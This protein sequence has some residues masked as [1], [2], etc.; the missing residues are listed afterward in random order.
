MG[1]E[2]EE[3]EQG[4]T[5]SCLFKPVWSFALP[6]YCLRM[7]MYSHT[8]DAL[9]MHIAHHSHIAACGSA[10]RPIRRRLHASTSFIGLSLENRAVDNDKSLLPDPCLLDGS[11]TKLRISSSLSLSLSLL[12]Q[13]GFI[14]IFTW[15]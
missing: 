8:I 4:T 15:V 13:N 2:K 10:S 7:S 3:S 1:V 6:S 14:S 11:S 5:L 9:Y 12:R